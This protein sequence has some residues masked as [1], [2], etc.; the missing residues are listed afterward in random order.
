MQASGSLKKCFQGAW[1][2]LAAIL[3]IFACAVGTV[4]YLGLHERT[5]PIKNIAAVSKKTGLSFPLGSKV[6]DGIVLTGPMSTLLIAR[7]SI[8]QKELAQF[9]MQPEFYGVEFSKLS[10]SMHDSNGAEAMIP[11]GWNLHASRNYIEADYLTTRDKRAQYSIMI[12]RD[13]PTTATI[14]VQYSN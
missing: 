3:I 12:D 5:E 6:R 4:L 13:D 8:P 7:I 2:M 1:V 9:L 14:Y 11:K 10:G